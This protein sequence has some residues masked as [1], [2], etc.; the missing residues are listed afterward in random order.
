[1]ERNN[2][3]DPI[4]KHVWNSTMHLDASFL[5]CF[6]HNSL[7]LV[8]MEAFYYGAAC[9]GRIGWWDSN[10]QPGPLKAFISFF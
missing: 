5:V 4:V 6:K 10:P 7:P 8:A 3:I 1:M 9:S 2:R